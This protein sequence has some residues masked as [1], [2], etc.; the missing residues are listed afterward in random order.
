[1]VMYVNSNV[2]AIDDELT[3]STGLE[4]KILE[5]G[6]ISLRLYGQPH[7]TRRHVKLKLDKTS[8]RVSRYP[9]DGQH[10]D[11]AEW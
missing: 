10:K 7:E 1:M 8:V 5:R 4:T 6:T 3:G 2:T 11:K 9:F